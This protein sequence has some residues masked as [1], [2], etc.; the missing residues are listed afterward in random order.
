M[1]LPELIK[2]LRRRLE[3]KEIGDQIRGI[4]VKI[5]FDDFEQTTLE[6]TELQEPSFQ[7]YAALMEM[8]YARGSRPVR[9]LGVGVRLMV[10]VDFIRQLELPLDLSGG[11]E[12]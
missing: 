3:R 11:R 8:A 7:N 1:A 5:K 2:S 12:L 10:D 6:R 9:L 4:F